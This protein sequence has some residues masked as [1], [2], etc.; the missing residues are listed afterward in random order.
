MEKLLVV[1]K[2]SSVKLAIVLS[3]S[4]TARIKFTEKEDGLSCGLLK[5]ILSGN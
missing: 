2:D 5:D 3:L 1:I 4:I